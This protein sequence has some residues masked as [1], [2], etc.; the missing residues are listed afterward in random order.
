MV[1]FELSDKQLLAFDELAKADNSEIVFGGAARGGKTFLGSFWIAASAVAMPDS[2][3][4]IAR[5]ELKALKR[6][7]MRTFFK[8][9]ALLKYRAGIHYRY[10]AQDMIVYFANGS[11]VF[12]AELKK[13]PSDPEFDR[14]GSYDLT[15]A[16][17]DEAQEVCKDAKDALQFRLTVT[18]GR[19]WQ[20]APKTLYTCNPS[21]GWIY[22][23][24]WKPLIKEKQKIKGRKFIVSLFTDNPYINQSQYKENVLRT[25]N[26][27][28]IERLLHGNFEYDDD[29]SKLIEYDRIVDI[30]TNNGEAGEKYVSC[31]VARMGKDKTIIMLWQ[32][33][34]IIKIYILI[35]KKTTEI[36]DK[37]TEICRQENVARSRV[38]IDEDGVGGGVVD[39]F[40]GC[41]GFVNNSSPIKPHGAKNIPN[42]LNLRSQCYYKLAELINGGKI[43]IA[44][45][46]PEQKEMV[47]EE[48]EQIKEKDVDKDSKV[49]IIPKE[50]IKEIIGRSPDFADT[51]MMRCFFEI[52]GQPI[53]TP[54]II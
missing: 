17:V 15:G 9:L 12:F 27:I 47:I 2:A 41:K 8:V 13:I 3:W 19:N 54:I 30:F 24:F 36:A 43:A 46:T 21:K 32:G 35:H 10:N 48:L 29:P 39:G 7:T 40:E 23:D 5:E 38:I 44:E 52:K 49:G 11:V 1:D 53:L 16:W 18:T 4:L 14:I 31:D 33:L 25:G 22:A 26:K 45:A 28:K 20:T 42:Y 50:K 51:L 6:T 34:R 37:L